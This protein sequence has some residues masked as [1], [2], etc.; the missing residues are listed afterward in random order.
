[1]TAEASTYSRTLNPKSKGYGKA[2]LFVT[3][4]RDYFYYQR[5]KQFSTLQFSQFPT[6]AVSDRSGLIYNAACTEPILAS[7]TS[8]MTADTTVGTVEA[9]SDSDSMESDEGDYMSVFAQLPSFKGCVTPAST[10]GQ[11]DHAEFIIYMLLKY[12]LLLDTPEIFGL[13]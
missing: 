8:P 7:V 2:C 13:F 5:R 1:M 10:I 11:T 6:I 12:I 3:I 9:G 4:K